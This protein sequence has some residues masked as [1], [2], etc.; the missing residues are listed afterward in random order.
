M[1]ILEGINHPQDTRQ[2]W[3]E[4]SVHQQPADIPA[5]SLPSPVVVS[6]LPSR[7]ET[8]SGLPWLSHLHGEYYCARSPEPQKRNKQMPQLTD[9][10][11]RDQPVSNHYLRRTSRSG[12]VCQAQ[13]NRSSYQKFIIVP[14]V[15]GKD[16]RPWRSCPRKL[17]SLRM[18]QN[19][20]W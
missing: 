1:I 13:W 10:H 5:H 14:K 3:V 20:G 19:S 12:Q 8:R 2:D 18:S 15:S 4:L 6:R 11:V 9:E 16:W 17:E 7:P